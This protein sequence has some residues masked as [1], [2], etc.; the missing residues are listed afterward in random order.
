MDDAPDRSTFRARLFEVLDE[1]MRVDAAVCG[2][3]CTVDGDQL[4]LEV[5]RG[6]SKHS[7]ERLARLKN[8]DPYACARAK[9]LARRVVIPDIRRDPQGGPYEVLGPSEGFKAVQS[10]PIVGS[11]GSVIGTLSTHYSQ[12]YS[13][14]RAAS[15]VL[16]Y[17]ARRAA[18][19]IESFRPLPGQ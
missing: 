13:P 1:A 10:T 9:Q 12:A 15:L 17:C 4:R 19:L 16:D 18:S 2:K 7:A 8:G 14:S 3:I 11:D 6:L 5:Q